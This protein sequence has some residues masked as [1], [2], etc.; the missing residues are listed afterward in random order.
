MH[1]H[2]DCACINRIIHGLLLLKAQSRRTEV[3]SN[4]ESTYNLLSLIFVWILVNQPDTIYICTYL[5]FV[6]FC[7]PPHLLACKLYT[8]KVRKFA[9]K[10]CLATKQRKSILGVLAVLVGI[11]AILVG[12][13]GVVCIWMVYLLHEIEPSEI[14]LVYLVFSLKKCEDLCL[15]SLHKL[16]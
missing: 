4:K 9:T 8:R 14:G 13:I 10:N 11:L 3:I 7:T 6:I 12:V 5:I 1:M 2:V 15:Y 16:C